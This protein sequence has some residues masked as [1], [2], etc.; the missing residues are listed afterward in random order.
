LQQALNIFS[1]KTAILPQKFK[2]APKSC[3]KHLSA[4]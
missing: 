1:G 4:R 2:Q 3:I